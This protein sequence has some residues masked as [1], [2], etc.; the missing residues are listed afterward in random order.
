MDF[1]DNDSN[2]EDGGSDDNDD[3]MEST[4]SSS[5]LEVPYAMNFTQHP[6]TRQKSRDGS[7][8]ESSS[9]SNG[10]GYDE[11]DSPTLTDDDENIINTRKVGN[12]PLRPGDVIE[13]QNTIVFTAGSK[14]GHSSAVVLATTNVIN[15]GTNTKKNS[16]NSNSNNTNN[17]R[18]PL[19]LSNGDC[20][21][22][23]V[24]IRRIFEY[25]RKAD[26]LHVH[27]GRLKPISNFKIKNKQLQTKDGSRINVATG[28]LQRAQRL[29]SIKRKVQQKA[30]EFLRG[31]HDEDRTNDRNKKITNKQEDDKVD[32]A[33]SDDDSDDTEMRAA[34]KELE[35]KKKRK[36]EQ[37]EQQQQSV[38]FVRSGKPSS[39]TPADGSSRICGLVNIEVENSDGDG[40]SSSDNILQRHSY[41]TSGRNSENKKNFQGNDIGGRKNIA[42]VN[43]TTMTK[44]SSL[45]LRFG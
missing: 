19:C 37:R 28:L 17:N 2:N 33:S 45:M 21:P 14:Q 18:F 32:D 11:Y 31:D 10:G 5:S 20:L 15:D 23:S 7:D 34:L 26:Q 1:G 29:R 4:S 24:C 44:N 35:E 41:S 8:S 43:L 25:D 40:S 3:E 42:I 36:Q 13:Y 38:G 6:A 16:S 22:S 30:V 12:E 9:D 27:R 39:S